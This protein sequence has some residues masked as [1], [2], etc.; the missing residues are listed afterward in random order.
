M[1]HIPDPHSQ[2][3][4]YATSWW[5]ADTVDQYL[6]WAVVHGWLYSENLLGLAR[7]VSL[8][9]HPAYWSLLLYLVQSQVSKQQWR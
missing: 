5:N 2:A 6:R 4:V 7:C 3:Y 9:A 1:L 8:S